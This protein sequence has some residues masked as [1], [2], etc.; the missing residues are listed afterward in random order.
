MEVALLF[1]RLGITAFGGPAAHIAMMRDEVVKRR[2]WVTE[3]QFLDLL[4]A[5][6]MIPG[7]TSTEMAIYLGYIRAGWRGL[8]LA[9]TLFILPAMVIVAGLAWAYVH[10]GSSLEAA[11]LLYGIKPVIIAIIVQALWGL[12]RTAMKGVLLAI[13]GAATLAMYFYGISPI[14][15]LFGGGLLA[16]LIQNVRSRSDIGKLAALASPISL[17]L[18]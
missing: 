6:N 12:S 7:P 9:G 16:M 3:Q 5:S 15:L 2:K 10:Y 11:A 18:G 14:A 8:V 1:L 17:S 13:I 4:G